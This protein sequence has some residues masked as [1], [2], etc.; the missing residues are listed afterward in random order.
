[1]LEALD[2]EVDPPTTVREPAKALDVH[3]ADS[4]AG[5][6]VPE[7][8][9]AATIADLGA[10]AGFPGLALAAA[11]PTTSVDLI[12]SARRKCQV[13]E[14]LAEAAGLANQT[15]ALPFRVE[16]WARQEGR[17]AYDAVTA[18]A[19]APLPV[20]AEYAAPL[21]RLGG[22]FV[23][24]KGSRQPDEEAAGARAATKLGLEGPRMMPVTPYAGSL[25]RHLYVYLK[26]TATPENYPRRS[27]IAVKRPLG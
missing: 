19:L 15:R 6:E 8:R 1:L 12:E 11:L 2:R 3:I 9:A 22:V 21:L 17:E 26:V 7:L 23:A 13:I 14:R 25:R 5:L 27:G 16:D 20:I 18:R 4:L 24:W 10:G